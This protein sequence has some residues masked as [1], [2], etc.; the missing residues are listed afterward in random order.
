MSISG[1]ILLMPQQQDRKSSQEELD[2]L[3]GLELEQEVIEALEESRPTYESI[4]NEKMSLLD[5]YNLETDVVEEEPSPEVSSKEEI[6]A[7]V[8]LA[9]LAAISLGGTP[10]PPMPKEI[11]TLKTHLRS[12][13]E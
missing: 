4:L 2:A 13:K 12:R 1:T 8:N 5:V 6:K 9:A 3:S 7:R 10:L 11:P